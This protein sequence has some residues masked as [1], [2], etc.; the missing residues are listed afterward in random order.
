MTWY[1]FKRWHI[2]NKS[3][4]WPTQANCWICNFT[5]VM[6]KM[7]IA[8][9]QRLKSGMGWKKQSQLHPGTELK[10]LCLFHHFDDICIF[11]FWQLSNCHCVKMYIPVQQIQSRHWHLL[12]SNDF[13]AITSNKPGQGKTWWRAYAHSFNQLGKPYDIIVEFHS[14]MEG[15]IM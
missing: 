4:Q 5:N 9:L 10:N 3:W 11:K 13:I 7:K 14:A 8:K 15:A 12:F 1:L 6:W 2:N